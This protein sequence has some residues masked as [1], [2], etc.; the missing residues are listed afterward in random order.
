MR[1]HVFH[2]VLIV[3]SNVTVLPALSQHVGYGRKLLS[4]MHVTMLLYTVTKGLWLRLVVVVMDSVAM[5]VRWNV[6][7][8]VLL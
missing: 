6:T 4:T 8:E 5:R 1:F 3:Q 7:N 2:P